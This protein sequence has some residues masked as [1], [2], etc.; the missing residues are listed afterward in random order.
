MSPRIGPSGP[1]SRIRITT[2]AIELADRE[3]LDAVSMRRVAD[4]LRTGPASLYRHIAG[5]EELVTAMVEHVTGEYAYP[6][7]SGMDWRD[8]MHAL[9]KQD[10]AALLAH[11]WLLTATATTTPPFGTA[12]L[13]AMEWALTALRRAGLSPAE[14]GRAV[15]TI[16]NYVQGAARVALG[17]QFDDVEGDPGVGWRRRLG[18]VDLSGFPEL[19]RLVSASV[20][21]DRDWFADGLD[22]ILDGIARRGGLEP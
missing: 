3:G 12:S 20:P 10:W 18:D 22:V 13:A 11:P 17:G 8:C 9:A 1:L 5:R 4:Q 14:S 6:D 15:M 2:A 19:Q 21:A 7:A 16:N